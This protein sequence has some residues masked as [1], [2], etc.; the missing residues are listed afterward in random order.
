M[1]TP[2]HGFTQKLGQ[3]LRSVVRESHSR[4][5]SLLISSLAAFN[6]RPPFR[7]RFPGER[8]ARTASFSQ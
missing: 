1:K 5:D 6:F 3:I 2:S 8:M 7:L 4:H